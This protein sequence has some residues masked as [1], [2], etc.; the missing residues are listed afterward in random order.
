MAASAAASATDTAE[1]ADASALPD[2]SACSAWHA[3][4]AAV[5]GDHHVVVFVGNNSVRRTDYFGRRRGRIHPLLFEK[6]NNLKATRPHQI[7]F[8]FTTCHFVSRSRGSCSELSLAVCFFL[9]GDCRFGSCN[10]ELRL[11]NGVSDLGQEHV[12]E[13]VLR[14]KIRAASAV[15]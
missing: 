6:R 15:E 12:H 1:L 8:V 5:T 14:L 2:A 11:R 9:G 3:M 7:E 4:H 10:S 13:I